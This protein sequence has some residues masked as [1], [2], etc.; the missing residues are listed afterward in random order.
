MSV[1][2][3]GPPIPVDAPAPILRSFGLLDVVEAIGE[4]HGVGDERWTNGAALYGWPAHLG[5]A[6]DPCA[7]GTFRT[8]D[9]GIGNPLPI[10]ASFTAYLPITCSSISIGDPDDFAQRS[11]EAFRAREG[12]IVEN[13]LATGSA[14]LADRNPHLADENVQIIAGTFTPAEALA[15]LEDALAATRQGGVFHAPP[16]LVSAWSD[17]LERDGQILRTLASWTPVVSGAGYL[18]VKPEESADLAGGDQQYA[19]ATF[20]VSIYRNEARVVPDA[21]S[22]ALSTGDNEVTYRAERDYL[23][24]YEAPHDTDWEG[25]LQA[26]VLADRAV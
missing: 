9:D 14:K 23:V 5:S 6:W 20:G 13:Q 8:K 12:A 2:T 3:F 17:Y 1:A 15:R 21:I 24:I 10:F 7:A 26:A 4:L 19:W 16:S 25:G 18:N 11:L 22:E